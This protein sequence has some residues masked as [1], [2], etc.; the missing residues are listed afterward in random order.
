[1]FSR[2]VGCLKRILHFL[3]VF[4][5]CLSFW[6][7]VLYLKQ[8]RH[9][10][11]NKMCSNSQSTTSFMFNFNYIWNI[12]CE[13]IPYI[14]VCVFILPDVFSYFSVRLN[15]WHGVYYQLGK[16]TIKYTTFFFSFLFFK[17]KLPFILLLEFLGSNSSE[18]LLVFAIFFNFLAV[19]SALTSSYNETYITL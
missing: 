10:F 8:I 2:A 12:S 19:K 1:M 3:S 17:S 15:I 13:I 14:Y 4:M 18:V 16:F 6:D 9:I 5:I 11:L 7:S